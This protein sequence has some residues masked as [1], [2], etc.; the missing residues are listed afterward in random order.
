MG[1]SRKP[2]PEDLITLFVFEVFRGLRGGREVI[3]VEIDD[4]VVVPSFDVDVSEG[5]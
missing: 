5:R 3:R 4:D 1:L 2:L